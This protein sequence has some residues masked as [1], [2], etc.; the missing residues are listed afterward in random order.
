MSQPNIANI[1]AESGGTGFGI[2]A[3]MTGSLLL[4]HE[5]TATR[6]YGNLSLWSETSGSLRCVS[7]HQRLRLGC[8][9]GEEESE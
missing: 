4:P 2:W 7:C 3:S 6:D 5:R 9:I 1:E 8:L